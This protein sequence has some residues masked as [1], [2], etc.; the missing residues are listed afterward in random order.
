MDNK[1]QHPN[2]LV[3]LSKLNI[4]TLKRMLDNIATIGEEH[5]ARIEA[6][7]ES[8]RKKNVKPAR[9]SK[10]PSP[11]KTDEEKEPFE[12][13]KEY[14]ENENKPLIKN[15]MANKILHHLETPPPEVQH[16]IIEHP[17]PDRL[18]VNLES[19]YEIVEVIVKY[20]RK[21]I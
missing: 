12:I 19:D 5:R 10:T 2:K 6:R 9:P 7:I 3:S 1:P 18:P 14:F 15:E 21:K 4:T 8:L 17:I 16:D 11:P 13:L 20:Q